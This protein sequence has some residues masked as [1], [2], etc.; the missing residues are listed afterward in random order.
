MNKF[1]CDCGTLL[2]VQE[3]QNYCFA[4]N[5]GF[6][7]LNSQQKVV[8][9]K[10]YV[11]QTAAEFL[12][13]EARPLIDEECP[14]CGHGRAYYTTQQMRSADEGQTVFFECVKCGYKYKTNT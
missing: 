3:H 14:K 2:D 5:K 1:C 13:Q 11:H 4:C 9:E 12:H 8:Q 7:K 6:K 10:V